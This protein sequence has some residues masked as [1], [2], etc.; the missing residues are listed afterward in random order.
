MLNYIARDCDAVVRFHSSTL[1][2]NRRGCGCALEV[3]H[4]LRRARGMV[5]VI[6]VGKAYCVIKVLR[7]A[8]NV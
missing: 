6:V 5:E 3:G 1:A 4:R 7:G 2:Q 8:F